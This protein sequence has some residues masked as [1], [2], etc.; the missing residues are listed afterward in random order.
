MT[1][2]LTGQ[3]NTVNGTSLKEVDHFSYLGSDISSTEKDVMIRI[4]KAWSALDKLRTIWKSNLPNALKR[5]FFRSTVESILLYGSSAWT[6]SRN[7]E[8]KLDGTY[9]RMLRAVLNKSW[10]QHPTKEELY[11]NIPVIS[12]IVRERR[13]KYAGHCYRSKDELVG[14]LLLWIPNHGHSGI[15]RPR[16]TCIDQLS[17]DVGM[18]VDDLK[19]SVEDR[20]VWRER[21]RLVRAIRPIR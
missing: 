11:G 3:I 21:V 2:K 12:E 15:G 7:L 8:N 20:D 4:A 13:T 19:P 10:N 17:N 18:P 9:T 5:N 1:F 14:D 6:L 16:R